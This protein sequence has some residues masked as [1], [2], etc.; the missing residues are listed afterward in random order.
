MFL[1]RLRVRDRERLG[2]DDQTRHQRRVSS[3][4]E[5]SRVFGAVD[6]ALRAADRRHSGFVAGGA[7]RVPDVALLRA[8]M[9]NSMFPSAPLIGLSITPFTSKPFSRAKATT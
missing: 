9:R 8:Y 6:G 7:S 1:V 2:R 5:A 4:C 3:P